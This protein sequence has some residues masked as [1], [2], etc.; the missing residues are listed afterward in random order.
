MVSTDRLLM[1]PAR[2][3][4]QIR[5]AY[6]P[7]TYSGG[8]NNSNFSTNPSIALMLPLGGE[9]SP[10]RNL[11]GSRL[12]DVGG[13]GVDA[14]WIFRHCYTVASLRLLDP[15]SLTAGQA[16]NFNQFTQVADNFNYSNPMLAARVSYQNHETKG[17]IPI[18]EIS[19][20]P[21]ATST[22]TSTAYSRPMS[23]V[24]ASDIE[25]PKYSRLVL[26]LGWRIYKNSSI[27]NTRL[28]AYIISG[29][30]MYSATEMSPNM[31]SATLAT[32]YAQRQV[33]YLPT[34]MSFDTLEYDGDVSII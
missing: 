9:F 24:V 25:I 18:T 34:F 33:F 15:V 17:L 13:G 5:N 31:T 16:F 1:P 28:T 19:Y 10:Y 4:A 27:T 7:V 20:N 29:S 12:A 32:A 23:C 3:I 2:S 21:T 22:Q 11:V 26:E 30:G 8:W 6:V 14:T